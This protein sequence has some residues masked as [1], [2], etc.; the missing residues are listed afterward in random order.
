MSINNVYTY[1]L[2]HAP[3]GSSIIAL[4]SDTRG[5]TRE[6]AGRWANGL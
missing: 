1:Y 4:S 2:I 3:L 5:M 6:M